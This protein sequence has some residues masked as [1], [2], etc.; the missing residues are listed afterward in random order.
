M[1]LAPIT[2]KYS[3]V[4]A[5]NP[6]GVIGV[7]CAKSSSDKPNQIIPWDIPEDLKN[8]RKITSAV[9]MTAEDGTS[10]QTAAILMGRKTYDTVAPLFTKKVFPN[11]TPIVLSLQQKFDPLHPEVVFVDHVNNELFKQYPIV[12][13]IGGAGLVNT[14]FDTFVYNDIHLT[15]VDHNCE[16]ITK[17]LNPVAVDMDKLGQI[18]L[19]YQHSVAE[20]AKFMGKCSLCDETITA[21]YVHYR[22][23]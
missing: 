14:T 3:L 4:L 1:N 23:V 9:T 10:I 2:T 7:D 18:L 20:D 12:H 16:K 17:D 19:A 8:F 11:R 22:K 5:V 21:T 15:H 13:N 6:S